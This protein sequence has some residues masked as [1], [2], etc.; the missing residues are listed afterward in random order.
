M[1]KPDLNLGQALKS[2]HNLDGRLV[3]DSQ[4][5]AVWSQDLQIRLSPDFPD[6]EPFLCRQKSKYRPDFPDFPGF[7]DLSERTN[8]FFSLLR[9]ILPWLARSARSV[10]NAHV[11]HVRGCAGLRRARPARRRRQRDQVCD[12]HPQYH[13][14]ARER[15]KRAGC[16]AVFQRFHMCF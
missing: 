6:S 16:L 14:R 5:P 8:A 9:H 12:D 15:F 3:A 13:P 2:G 4:T 10:C 11:R 7:Q 1:S